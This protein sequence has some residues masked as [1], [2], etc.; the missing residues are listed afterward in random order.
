MEPCLTG[1]APHVPCASELPEAPLPCLGVGGILERDCRLAEEAPE[2]RIV[3][4]RVAR[5]HGVAPRQHQPL[6]LGPV[7]DNTQQRTQRRPLVNAPAE[8]RPGIESQSIAA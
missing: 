2:E 5:D 4:G 1:S 3:A 8:E 6:L 7:I